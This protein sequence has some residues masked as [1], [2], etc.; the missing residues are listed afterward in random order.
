MICPGFSADCL[1]TLDEI[2]VEYRDEFLQLG[3]EE[4]DYIPA[5]NDR[6]AHIEMMRQLVEPYLPGND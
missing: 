2:K 1:E 3:G 5:L 4:F 6:E